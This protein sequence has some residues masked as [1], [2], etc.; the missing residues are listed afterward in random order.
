MHI[1]FKFIDYKTSDMRKCLIPVILLLFLY[2]C[3]CHN[4]DIKIRTQVDTVGFAQYAWQ[5]DSIIERID[6]VDRPTGDVVYKAVICPHDDYAY[7]AGLYTK[8]L[9]DVKAPVVIMVGVAHKARLF[10]LENKL[11]FGTFNEWK[12]PY[13]N[14]KVSGLRDTLTALLSPDSFIVHDSMM[15][16][17]HSLEAIVPFLQY[18]NHD[19]EIVPLL[20]PYMTFEKMLSISEQFAVI[21]HEYME[22]NHLEFGNDIAIVISNDALHYGDEDWGGEDMAPFGCDSTG[23]ARANQKD[24]EIISRTLAGDLSTA[25]I[26]GFYKYT[27]KDDDFKAYAWTWCGRYSVPFG[28]LLS[29]DLNNLEN[30]PPL[31]GEVLGYRS[32]ILNPH[33]RV[34]DLGMGITAP[35]NEHHWV[36]YVGAGYR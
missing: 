11:V 9:E 23:N 31:K 3:G 25:K 7:V 19:I 28:L 10:N 15:T 13:G 22:R 30:N 29:E 1:I 34:D 33:I 4:T 26:N 14:V 27:V 2:S 18:Y 17:E 32:S 36:S 24:M 16:I 12:A 20:V 8:T 21:L 6:P 35:A 5:M